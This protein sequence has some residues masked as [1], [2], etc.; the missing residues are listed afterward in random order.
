MKGFIKKAW[1]VWLDKC[2][3]VTLIGGGILGIAHL[4][5]DEI[6]EP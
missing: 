5:K 6:K 3:K 2:W 4:I 1:D